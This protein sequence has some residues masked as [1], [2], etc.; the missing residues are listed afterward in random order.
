MI[1]GIILTQ[2]LYLELQY[3]KLIILWYF[4]M[5]SNDF[6]FVH[7]YYRT[8][9]SNVLLVYEN[10]EKQYFILIYCHSFM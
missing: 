2:G 3:S 8:L 4:Q 7:M 5:F 1:T 9:S 6:A 10:R